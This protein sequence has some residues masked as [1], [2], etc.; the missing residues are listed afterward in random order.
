MASQVSQDSLLHN[1]ASFGGRSLAFIA[2]T[3]SAI[4]ILFALLWLALLVPSPKIIKTTNDR[5]K[6]STHLD[7]DGWMVTTFTKEVTYTYENGSTRSVRIIE[8]TS[9]KGN[10]TGSTKYKAS[11]KVKFSETI[12]TTGDVP[13]DPQMISLSLATIAFLLYFPLMDCSRFQG[14]PG[15]RLLKLYVVNESGGRLSFGKAV[16]RNIAKIFSVGCLFGVLPMLGPEKN[17]PFHDR[18]TKTLVLAKNA[19]RE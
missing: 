18:W 10:Q 8:R 9:A 16:L 17:P 1:H 3:I 13:F 19:V 6:Q 5:A 11:T 15:K 14:T 2:D 12:G 4:I 7:N